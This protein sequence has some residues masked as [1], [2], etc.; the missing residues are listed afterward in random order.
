MSTI[1]AKLELDALRNNPDFLQNYND[2]IALLHKSG[3]FSFLRS[4]A[5]CFIYDGGSN[6][7]RSV[8]EAHHNAGYHNAL[9]DV[10]FFKEQYLTESAQTR[11]PA[12]DFGGRKAA[13]AR[14]DLTIQDIEGAKK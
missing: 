9:N 4:N 12:M 1:V 5:R 7:A 6:P 10:A 2:G 8:F 3:I 11:I 14:G 13:L